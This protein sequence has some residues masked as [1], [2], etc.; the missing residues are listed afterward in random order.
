MYNDCKIHVAQRPMMQK[1]YGYGMRGGGAIV[2]VILLGVKKIV[3]S[4]K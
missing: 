3:K 2:L 4:G 1:T